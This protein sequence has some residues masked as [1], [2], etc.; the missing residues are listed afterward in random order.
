[1][2]RRPW[3]PEC[4]HVERSDAL[5]MELEERRHT[6][7]F[8]SGSEDVSMVAGTENDEPMTA[9]PQ[10]LADTFFLCQVGEGIGKQ[11]TA[12][13]LWWWKKDRINY[14]NVETTSSG[15]IS[16]L[17]DC[18]LSHTSYGSLV[19]VL[20]RQATC[21][22]NLHSLVRAWTWRAYPLFERDYHLDQT[23]MRT[24]PHVKTQ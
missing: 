3:L 16:W 14:G 23:H 4:R 24:N 8:A 11:G 12:R 22:L 5:P 1:M 18:T 17:H 20:S 6:I 7:V 19:A 10:D 2:A 13:Q 9:N 15:L 21:H